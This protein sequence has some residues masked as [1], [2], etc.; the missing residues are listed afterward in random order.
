M[1][2]WLLIGLG[3]MFVLKPKPAQQAG[4]WQPISGGKNLANNNL[5]LNEYGLPVALHVYKIDFP[6]KPGDTGNVITALQ[7]MIAV[8]NFDV[9]LTGALDAVTMD[10]FDPDIN[11][12]TLDDFIAFAT[13]TP[14]IVGDVI[15]Y[16]YKPPFTT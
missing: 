11:Q 5:P 6:L 10:A 1:L 16:D 9:P 14:P 2:R 7:A 3:A 13:D 12:I 15:V 8:R 4:A